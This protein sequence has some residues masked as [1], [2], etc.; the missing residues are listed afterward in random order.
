MSYGDGFFDVPAG[1][2]D[3]DLEMARMEDLG[4]RYAR[5]FRGFSGASS[6]HRH[7]L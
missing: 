1:Y 2:S 7:I 6:Q 5:R 3:A 4:T